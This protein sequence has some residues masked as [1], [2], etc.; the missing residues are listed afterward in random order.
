VVFFLVGKAVLPV[1]VT[2]V[3]GDE[4]GSAG[5]VEGT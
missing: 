3:A 4:E 1:F 2:F 5:M